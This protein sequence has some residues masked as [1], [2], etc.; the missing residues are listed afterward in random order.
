M[1]AFD[2]EPSTW[3]QEEYFALP[4]HRGQMKFLRAVRDNGMMTGRGFRLFCEA[5]LEAYGL[6]DE[7]NQGSAI[8]L[9]DFIKNAPRN[10]RREAERTAWREMA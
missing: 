10:S 9:I 5:V 1:I 8:V 2:Y 3:P 4:P 6:P 7:I